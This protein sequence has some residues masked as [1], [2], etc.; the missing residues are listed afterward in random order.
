MFQVSDYASV[1]DEKD[2]YL[3]MFRHLHGILRPHVRF[4]RRGRFI[5]SNIP[6]G[7]PYRAEAA[8]AV[9]RLVK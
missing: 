9:K 8:E 5:E 2:S 1:Y 7:H 4:N 3:V 6:E